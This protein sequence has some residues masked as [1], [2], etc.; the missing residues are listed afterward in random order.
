MVPSIWL[1]MMVLQSV[2]FY[3]LDQQGRSDDQYAMEM[4][5]MRVIP[6][7]VTYPKIVQ[8]LKV[9]TYRISEMKLQGDPKKINCQLNCQGGG[10]VEQQVS[11][12]QSLFIC[13][14]TSGTT[15]IYL[16]CK[17]FIFSRPEVRDTKNQRLD[18]NIVTVTDCATIITIDTLFVTIGGRFDVLGW[19]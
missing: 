16:E 3:W 13:T 4:H 1:V 10:G 18:Y 2:T 5:Y 8:N 7:K 19:D 9:Q 11:T 14:N 15:L 17:P 12:V 6:F